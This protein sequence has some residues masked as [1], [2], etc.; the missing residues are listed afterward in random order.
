MSDRILKHWMIICLLLM[1]VHLH[2]PHHHHSDG[3]PHHLH[4]SK[5]ARFRCTN[6]VKPTSGQC[7]V[8]AHTDAQQGAKVQRLSL[9]ESP[10]ALVSSVST[11]QGDV[12][13]RSLGIKPEPGS[14]IIDGQL[15]SQD[16]RAP[17]QRVKITS[18]VRP[19]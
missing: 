4:V 13:L 16:A 7:E 9:G 8:T 5:G 3:E 10:L 15:E 2:V 19:T 11:V 18:P 1:Q 17:P 14:R 6:E 12:P